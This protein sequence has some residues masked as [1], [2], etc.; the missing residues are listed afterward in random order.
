MIDVVFLLLVF[1][2]LVS[3][4]SRDSALPLRAAG[5]GNQAQ[6]WQGPEWL[7][8][9]GADGALSLNG[10]SITPAHLVHGLEPLIQSFDDPIVLRARGADVQGLVYIVVVLRDAGFTRLIVMR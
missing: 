6:A 3:Q 7:V 9:L 2:M 4:F 8:D 5:G 1:F 10:Q